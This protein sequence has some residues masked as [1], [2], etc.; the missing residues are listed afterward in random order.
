MSDLHHKTVAE[1]ATLLHNKTL[2]S[3]ELTQHFLSRIQQYNPKLNAYICTTADRA[4][5]DAKASDERRQK[6]AA[7]SPLD[8]I[9]MG[10]KD[11]FCTKGIAT[12]A[13]SK[14]L[15]RFIPSYTATV[16]A[17]LEA[18]GSVLTGKLSMDEF[19][20]GSSNERSYFGAVCNPWDE[21]RIPG[22]SSGGS[23]TA[24][25]ARLIPYATGS[26]TGGSVRQPAAYCGITGI[27]PTYGTCSRWGMI[28][29]ASSLDQAGVL[30]K[31]AQDCA[32]ILNEMA[33]HDPKDSTSNPKAL[34]QFDHE[35]NRDLDGITIGLPSNYLA[36]LDAKI[37]EKIQQAAALYE[38]LGATI[39]EITLSA[40]DVAIASYYLISSAEA[41]SN[42]ERFDGVHYGYRCANPKDLSDLYE[43]SR[44][45]GFGAEVKRRIMIGTYA[46][47]AGY[48]DAYYEQARR[49]R[50]AILNS[51][52]QAFKECDVILGPTTPT[53][54][55]P[56]GSKVDDPVAMFLG[57]LYTVSANLAGLPA[58]SHPAGF[59]DG[60]PVGCQL[61]GAHFS[62]PRLLNLA[63]RFQ[64]ETDFHQQ[65][66]EH[67]R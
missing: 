37:A 23:A 48:Y 19:A 26:D 64:Q 9:P 66:P 20:M 4:L 46:L 24:V 65:I 39:K 43:R 13:G 11:L 14:M 51:F 1:L 7:H 52:L 3:V 18:A 10:H 41:S 55:Y 63:H 42:L 61:I 58:L 56:L 67:Y 32:L 34:T 21:Q 57:D 40:T 45:E 27:K 16:V 5:A 60:L 12:T 31:T 29:Y 38:K 54:A 44:S 17:R 8:G 2:S 36:G 59:I 50:R 6:G 22:G 53:T 15:E 30:A 62:E 49:G 28:A 33:G 47:S 25:A 35:L